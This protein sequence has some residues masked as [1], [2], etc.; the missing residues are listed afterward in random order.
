MNY[1]PALIATLAL[2]FTIASFYWLQ[3]RTGRLKLYPIVVFSGYL[4]RSQMTLRLPL[5]IFNSGAKPRVVTAL[6]LHLIT[7]AGDNVTMTCHAFRRTI[8]PD[9]NDMED[10]PV[11]FIIPPRAVTTKFAEF[12]LDPTPLRVLSNVP[13]RAEVEAFVDQKLRWKRL[14]RAELHME[15]MH[16]SSFITYSNHEGAWQKDQLKAAAQYREALREVI[17]R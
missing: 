2:L 3:A 15:I 8:K 9:T 11:A 5:T 7:G 17:R 16:D 6:R 12:R 10:F 13:T 14:G 1:V 4:T